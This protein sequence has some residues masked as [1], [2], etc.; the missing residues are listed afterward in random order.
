MVAGQ[1]FRRRQIPCFFQIDVYAIISD[2]TGTSSH[3]MRHGDEKSGSTVL[4]IFDSIGVDYQFH[5]KVGSL[6]KG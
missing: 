3:H 1:H 4:F 5:T 2:L 6:R